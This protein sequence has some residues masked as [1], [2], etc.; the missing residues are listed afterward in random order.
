MVKKTLQNYKTTAFKFLKK[1]DFENAGTYLSLA[2]NKRKNKRLLVLIDLCNLAKSRY[3]E[4]CLLSDFYLENKDNKGVDEDLFK[5]MNQVKTL[6][7]SK[8]EVF[9]YDDFCFFEEKLGFKAVLECVIYSTK[10][11]LSNKDE[12]LSFLDKLLKNGHFD[13][14]LAYLVEFD[15]GFPLSKKFINFSNRLRW[16]HE[17]KARK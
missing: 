1:K 10:L 2:Y 16:Y 17:N 8:E 7:V 14:V 15:V 12:F 3:F 11:V 13:L 9:S 4:A 5:L 6:E